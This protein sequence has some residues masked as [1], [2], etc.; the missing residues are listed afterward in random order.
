MSVHNE[1]DENWDEY[2]ASQKRISE[3]NMRALEA[4]KPWHDYV[5]FL[6]GALLAV[7]VAVAVT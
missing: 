1:H 7:I 3:Q 6:I 4:H 5:K 2:Y